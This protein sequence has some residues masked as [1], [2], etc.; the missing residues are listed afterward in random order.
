MI[1]QHAWEPPGHTG[2][3]YAKDLTVR[4]DNTVVHFPFSGPPTLAT[5]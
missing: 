5:F 3:S 1:D 2:A 4:P